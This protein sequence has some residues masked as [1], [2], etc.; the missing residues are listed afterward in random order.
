MDEKAVMGIQENIAA[1]ERYGLRAE[2]GILG[3]MRAFQ[4]L[5]QE[6]QAVFR[7]QLAPILSEQTVEVIARG[8]ESLPRITQQVDA[9]LTS[10]RSLTDAAQNVATTW[11]GVWGRIGIT[12]SNALAILQE[13]FATVFGPTLLSTVDRFFVFIRDNQDS[14]SNFFAGVRDGITPIVSRIWNTVREAYPDIKAFATDVWVELRKQFE[15]IAPVIQAVGGVVMDIARAIGAFATEHPR[16]VATLI[17]GVVAW[18]AYQIAAGG[19]GVVADLVKGTASLVQGHLHKLNAT[20]LQNARVSGTLQTASLSIGRVF[21]GIGRAALSAIPGIAA[22]GGTITAAIIPALPVILPVVAAVAAL[23]AAAYIV[24]RNW[25]PIKAFF[26]DNFDTIRNVLLLVFP[27]LGLLVSFADVIKQNWEGVKEFFATIW[28]TIK[29]TAMVAF[30]TVKFV[31]LNAL[32]AVSNAWSGVTGFFGNLWQGVVDIFVATPLAPI[33]QWMTENVMAVVRP[34]FGFFDNFWQNV[35][36]AAGRVLN[37]ITDKFKA[38]NGLLQKVLGWL[39]DRNEEI[40]DELKVV[41][42][43]GMDVSLPELQIGSADELNQTVTQTAAPDVRV[44]IPTVD[45]PDVGVQG[46]DSMEDARRDDDAAD[47]HA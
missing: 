43:V 12:G 37:W 33:F 47:D 20:I 5:N 40:Q 21:G 8:S 34:L 4:L 23:G 22:M 11:S 44:D 7:E 31:G 35:A 38:I 9:I 29:L 36:D 41:G 10:E 42:Q 30:E 3:A 24:Y 13:Q 28:D 25:E 19:F 16:L 2:D 6:Q 15:L 27:P 17:T 14:I 18:K 46:L 45:M 32:L 26:I 1:L 39:R